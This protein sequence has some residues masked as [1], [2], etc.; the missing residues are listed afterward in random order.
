M[1]ASVLIRAQ[2]W[3]RREAFVSG[4]TAAGHKVITQQPA[5]IDKDTLLVIWNRYNEQ[6]ELALRVEAAGGRV[7]VAENGYIGKGGIAPKF[8]VHPKGPTAG[9]YYALAESHHNGAGKWKRGEGD[10][11]PQLQLDLKPL[12]PTGNHILVCP[13]RGFGPPPMTMHP[14]WA[15]RTVAHLRTITSRPVRLRQHP[16]NSAP[17]RPLAEDLRDAFATV[18]WSSAAGVHS[19]AA[20]VPV[21]AMAPHWVCM[22]AALTSL[23]TISDAFDFPWMQMGFEAARARAMDEMAWQQWTVDEISRG[24]PFKLLLS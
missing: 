3:Y 1:L 6:H 18:I 17:T 22:G 20:G 15:E 4:L 12:R 11:L 23:E 24:I 21:F 8:D 16:G 2:P 5:K 7:L 19:L 9:S 10:R 14:D 13:N